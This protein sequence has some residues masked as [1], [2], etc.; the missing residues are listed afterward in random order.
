M[1]SDKMIAR[2]VLLRVLRL[3]RDLDAHLEA[4]LR[5]DDAVRDR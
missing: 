3:A 5:E 1:I 4:G 2:N